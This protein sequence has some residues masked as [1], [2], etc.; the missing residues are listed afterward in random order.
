MRSTFRS[1]SLLAA[2]YSDDEDRRKVQADGFPSRDAND[3]RR[4]MAR[5]RVLLGAIIVDLEA[6]AFVRCR[7][8]NVSDGGACLKLSERRFLPPTFWLVPTTSG[9]AYKARIAWRCDNRLGVSLGEP[10]DL[11]DPATLVER[12]LR[13]IWHL[14][15]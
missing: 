14:A 7:L 5:R 4:S 6:D 2:S 11:N 8:E 12:R 1:I 9:L 13:R 10:G 15:C 3:G